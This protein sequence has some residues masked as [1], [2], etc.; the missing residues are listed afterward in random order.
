MQGFLNVSLDIIKY[1][2]IALNNA[3]NGKAA[4]VIKANAYGLGMFPITKTL[5]DA[6]C[7]YFYL[8]N[9]DEAVDLRKKY[10][11]TDI[12]IA[13][14]EGFF[15]G[16]E[17]IYS[18]NNL[19]P[20]IN[21]LNQLKRLNKFNCSNQNKD[22]IKAILHIDTGMNRLG[23][24]SEEIEYIFENQNILKS[25][26]WEFA[27]SHL[28]NSGEVQNK[29]N[30]EQLNKINSF[31]QLFPYF[32][33][34]LANTGG[35]VLGDQFCLD[36]TR[37][38]IGLYGI[39]SFGNN[40]NLKT[41]Q[42]KVPFELFGPI[43]QIKDVPIGEE[44][45][46]GGKDRTIRNS[47]LATIGIG[48][49]DGW[50]RLLKKNSCFLIDGQECNI[51]GNITMDSFILDITDIKTKILK[52][53]SYIKFIDKSNLKDILK[54]LDLISY[55]FLTLIGNRIKRKYY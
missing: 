38:G 28:T 14:F 20:I 17:T 19:I 21:N 45:S 42:L 44:V 51:I 46:Y 7:N 2:W 11:S 54:S 43:I 49:A 6:G 32:K 12:S 33:L 37:P 5:I 15:K 30:K 47:K 55:E 31:S 41:K 48:Y 50:L 13:V 25:T 4:A 1:N 27:M 9:L 8:A 18:N 22:S 34:S 40:I 26:M 39:D 53:G 23:L 24:K 36:Q 52:E 16:N 35:I 10:P 3:S 29:T